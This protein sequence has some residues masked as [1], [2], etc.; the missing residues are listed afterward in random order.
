M[1]R[2]ERTGADPAS[3]APRA[4][5]PGGDQGAPGGLG[6]SGDA[7]P[8]FCRFHKCVCVCVCVCVYAY[9]IMRLMLPTPLTLPPAAARCL[10]TTALW[11][12]PSRTTTSQAALG[13]RSP[14]LRVLPG[15][16]CAALLPV[17]P[18]RQTLRRGRPGRPSAPPMPV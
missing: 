9:T 13:Q 7:G 11:K 3:A 1:T 16:T 5:G 15:Q 2:G 10:A 17:H 6:E 4:V 14:G 18:S 8:S 12:V